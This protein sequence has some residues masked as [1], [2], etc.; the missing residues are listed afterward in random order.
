[1]NKISTLQDPDV[2]ARA[3]LGTVGAAVAGGAASAVV[4]NLLSQIEGLF[5]RD[6]FDINTKRDLAGIIQDASSL[7][8]ADK[9]TVKTALMNKI[10]TLE[11][12]EVAARALG[13]VGSAVAGGAASAIVGN[14][15][16]RECP[17][18]KS[19]IRTKI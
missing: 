2:S 4:G 14:L 13:A 9:E 18:E 7:P 16:G 1:M 3:I 12:P 15:L 6:E 5:R 19:S 8:P 11:E 10:S 17:N